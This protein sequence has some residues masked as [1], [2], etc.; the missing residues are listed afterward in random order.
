MQASDASVG[1][2]DIVRMF[3]SQPDLAE[4]VSVEKLGR[5]A[6]MICALNNPCLT[7][8]KRDFDMA[9]IASR[10][11]SLRQCTRFVYDSCATNDSKSDR[12]AL[13]YT[14]LE[15]HLASRRG[16]G[17]NGADTIGSVG[18]FYAAAT[19]LLCQYGDLLQGDEF[20]S[21]TGRALESLLEADGTANTP[22]E[23]EKA[24]CS[25]LICCGFVPNNANWSHLVR[26]QIL[27]VL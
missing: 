7:Q 23:Q 18:Y 14:R 11:D 24:H 12:A 9:F 22:E 20:T 17:R 26:G 2:N 6:D 21:M 27:S 16:R 10:K 5:M 4:L 3:L 13:F 19:Y 1:R 15:R 8:D 25:Q